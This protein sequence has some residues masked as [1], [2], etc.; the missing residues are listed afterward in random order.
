MARKGVKIDIKWTKIKLFLPNHD[1]GRSI[2]LF[3]YS[4][5]VAI[6]FGDA[7]GLLVPSLDSWEVLSG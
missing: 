3:K 5:L 2:M 6:I 4:S 1:S 7:D